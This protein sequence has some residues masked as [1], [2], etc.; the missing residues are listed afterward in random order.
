[1][2]DT[3]TRVIGYGLPQHLIGTEYIAEC[4]SI[5]KDTNCPIAIGNLYEILSRKHNTNYHAVERS[6]RYAFTKYYTKNNISKVSNAVGL[7]IL[8]SKMY[9]GDV[10]ACALLLRAK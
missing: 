10:R 6:M 3:F 9:G 1:M 7:S 2:D 5:M 4:L 8:Y